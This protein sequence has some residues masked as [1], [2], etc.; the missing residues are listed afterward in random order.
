MSRPLVDRIHLPG[1]NPSS[2]I[3]RRYLVY[4]ITGNPGLVE[5]YDAFLLHLYMILGPENDRKLFS[6]ENAFDIYAASIPGFDF[7]DPDNAYERWKR[8]GLN[9]APPFS[10]NE[11]IDGMEAE[12]WGAVELTKRDGEQLEVIIMGH[13]LGSFITLELIQRH[14]RR[15][16]N[17]Q[18]EPCVITAGIC[19]FAT[20]VDIASSERGQI[21]SAL[22]KYIPLFQSLVPLLCNFVLSLVPNTLLNT[23]IHRIDGLTGHCADVTTAFLKSKHGVTQALYM[24]ADEMRQISSDK[25]DEEIWGAAHPSRTGIP[26]P[27]MFFYF[28]EK[29]HW[30]A[31]R[32][33]EDL[34]KFRGRGN[35]GD[36]WKPKMEIDQNGIPHGF[37]ISHSI[38]IAEKVRQYVKEIVEAS[39]L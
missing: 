22:S 29:D 26:R 30:V 21:F 32:T 16:E 20:V 10:L 7:A 6:S 36:H 33:R 19:L 27:K 13:S 14:R 5:Y 2:H 1:P 38:P 25:W 9:H 31:D 11:V 28:G 17:G 8:M 12:L 39:P 34:M 35:G 18:N 4:F 23:I 15:L 37:C 3:K 24:G